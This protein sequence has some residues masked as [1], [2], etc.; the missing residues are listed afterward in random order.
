[1]TMALVKWIEGLNR[2]WLASRNHAAAIRE[3]DI[4]LLASALLEEGLKAGESGTVVHVYRNGMA[5]EVEFITPQG[6]KVIILSPTQIKPA[7]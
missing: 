2:L 1:M 3:H 7:K 4:V 5:F 6:S